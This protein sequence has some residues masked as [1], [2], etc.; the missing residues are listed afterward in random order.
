MPAW[1]GVLHKRRATTFFKRI[2]GAGPPWLL[3]AQGARWIVSL[4]GGGTKFPETHH[5]KLCS[6]LALWRTCIHLPSFKTIF[7]SNPQHHHSIHPAVQNG[8]PRSTG[9]SEGILTVFN[10]T[11]TSHSRFRACTNSCSRSLSFFRF[12]CKPYQSPQRHTYPVHFK[13]RIRF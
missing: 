4:Q 10:S 11:S 12:N 9:S 3:P 1:E 7:T 13:T 2:D 6:Q 5:F 8:I